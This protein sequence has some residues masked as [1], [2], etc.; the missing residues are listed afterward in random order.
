M[1]A[2]PLNYT[3]PERRTAGHTPDS[4][5]NMLLVEKRF[6]DGTVRMHRIEGIINE[7]KMVTAGKIEELH[8]GQQAMAITHKRFEEKLDANTAKTDKTA[9]DTEEILDI[10]TLGKS[11]FRLA[12]LFGKVFKWIAGIATAAI[13]LWLTFK[14]GKPPP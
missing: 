10:L 8:Q 7:L 12:E 13:G 5:P 9:A 14:Y 3:G 1:I 11:F 2:A 4:C 6:T